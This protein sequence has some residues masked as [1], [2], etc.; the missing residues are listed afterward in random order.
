MTPFLRTLVTF[1]AAYF[2]LLF[3]AS[4]L[5]SMMNRA[6][7]AWWRGWGPWPEAASIDVSLSRAVEHRL[8]D[9]FTFHAAPS[10][11]IALV[12]TL[13]AA[14]FAVPLGAIARAVGRARVDAGKRDPIEA[15]RRWTAAHP[16]WTRA[17]TIVPSALFAAWTNW[18]TF[19]EF[20]GNDAAER[21][22]D[23]PVWGVTT[24]LTTVVLTAL[25]RRGVRAL[26]APAVDPQAAPVQVEV[27]ANEITF[28]AVAV[29]RETVGAVAGMA[30]LSV[31]AVILP[32]T[33]VDPHSVWPMWALGSYLVVAVGGAWAFRQASKIRVGV[34]GVFV[35]G[36]SRTRFFAYRDLDGARVDR[37]DLVLVRR[38]RV[39][40][41]L[42]LHGEDAARRDAILARIQG[43]VARTSSAEQAR[44]ARVATSA[45]PEDLARVVSGG[46]G[47]RNA[48][49][50][51]D[52]LWALVEGPTVDVATRAAAAEALAKTGDD[53]QR[54]R[55]RV[56][57]ETC[58]DPAAR[59]ALEALAEAQEED[60]A[61]HAGRVAAR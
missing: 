45:S 34:D 32:W 24:V 47:Y 39:V 25:L 1:V 8:V 37:G 18:L 2:G 9:L 61:V 29:T 17:L 53:A 51:R 59:A 22:A 50:T 14:T 15:L 7:Q 42:Q 20:V 46:A 35:S 49:L 52:E 31:A 3:L 33:N 12:L 4:P 54:A 21:V 55:I 43:A 16:A 56:V 28:D 38:D 40:L 6:H 58:A 11:L 23:A 27:D 5:D 41:R 36:T 19:A 13:F 44:A 48:S 30:A 10:L 57:A 26:V 60:G